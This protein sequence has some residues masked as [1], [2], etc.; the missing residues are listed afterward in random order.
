VLA[1][2]HIHAPAVFP[3]EGEP[4]HPEHWPNWQHAVNRDRLYDYYTKQAEYFRKQKPVPMLLPEFPGL[5]GGQFGHWGNQNEET[6]ASARWNETR[7]GSVQCGIFRGAGVT[8]ARGVCVRLGERGE[9]SACFNP[10][11]LNYD[12][13]WSDGLVKFSSVRHGLLHGLLLDGRPMPPPLAHTPDKPFVYRGFYRHGLRVVFSYRIGDTEYLDAP[14]VED[15]TFTRV[16]AP[17]DDHPL[18]HLTTAGKPQWPQ[19]LATRIVQGSRTP[20]TRSSCQ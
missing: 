16:V 11:T 9:L 4:L 12:A 3:V 10:D 18:K 20:S 6:W 19:H 15:G 2:A 5:D 8:V 13:V 1:H 7:L 14:W 17:A